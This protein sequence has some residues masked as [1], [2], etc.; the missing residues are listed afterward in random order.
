MSLLP[1]SRTVLLLVDIQE[2]LNHPSYWGISPSN[3]GFKRNTESLITSYRSLISST[4]SQSLSTPHKLIHIQHVSTNQDSPLWPSSS[5]FPFQ[6]WA[7]PTEDELVIKK[8]AHSAFIGTNLEKALRE[9]FDGNPGILW[10]AGLALDQSVSSTVRM[11]ENLGVCD[12]VD[13]TKGRVSLIEDAT[14]AWEKKDGIKADTVHKVHVSSLADFATI[15]K[16]EEVLHIWKGR[17]KE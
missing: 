15:E 10:I 11:A 2:G 17:V 13:G 5:G 1:K 4:L 8:S 6:N 14:A 3:P 7:A 12:G 16:T 9:H